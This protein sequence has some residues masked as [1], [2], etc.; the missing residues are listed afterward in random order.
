[1]KTSSERRKLNRV[2]F[3]RGVNVQIV[4]IDGT[5]VAPCVMLDASESGAKLRIEQVPPPQNLKEF[6]LVL[7]TT[8]KAFRRCQLAWINGELIGVNFLEK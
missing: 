1:M 2:R 8:G 3:S 6:F 5:W 7:S 4:A